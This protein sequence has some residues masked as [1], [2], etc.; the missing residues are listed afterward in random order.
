M[1]LPEEYR[2]CVTR[3]VT[4]KILSALAGIM[5]DEIKHF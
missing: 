2:P 3:Y 1:T 4:I 5:A